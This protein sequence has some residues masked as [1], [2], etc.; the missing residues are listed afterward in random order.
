ML[1]TATPLTIAAVRYSEQSGSFPVARSNAGG[2]RKRAWR[3]A[4]REERTA[5]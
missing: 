1:T 2:T 4:Y 3:S 5:R